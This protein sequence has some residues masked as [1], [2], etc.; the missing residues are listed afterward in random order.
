MNNS[1]FGKTT[2]NTEKRVDFRLVTEEK[3]LKLTENLLTKD[4]QSSVNVGIHMI[5]TKIF[6]SKPMYLVMCILDLRKILM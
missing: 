6:H 1:M 2:E 3:A 5:K 4:E